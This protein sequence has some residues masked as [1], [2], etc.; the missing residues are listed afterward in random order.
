MWMWFDMFNSELIQKSESAVC[1]NVNRHQAGPLNCIVQL[2]VCSTCKLLAWKVVFSTCSNQD[3]EYG[4]GIFN[5]SSW[6]MAAL[7]AQCTSS[8]T[9]T[10]NGNKVWWCCMVYHAHASLTPE[11]SASS[12]LLK[13]AQSQTPRRSW[14]LWPTGPTMCVWSL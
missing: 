3:F 7:Y 11:H 4:G 6:P 5:W 13:Q 12:G 10:L 1:R 9:V 8:V 2:V 14:W